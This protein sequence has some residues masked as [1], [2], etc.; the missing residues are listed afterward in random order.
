L[1]FLAD[2]EKNTFKTANALV[3]RQEQFDECLHA[4]ELP[5]HENGQAHRRPQPP[6][7][8]A[9]TLADDPIVFHAEPLVRA[10][11]RNRR[12]RR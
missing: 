4:L 10:R 1:K 5:L 8:H 11:R 9:E 7:V 3:L 6:R 12:P 2:V